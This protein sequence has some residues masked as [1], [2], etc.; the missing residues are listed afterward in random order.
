MSPYPPPATDRTMYFIGVT[1]GRSAVT[2]VFPRWAE[3]LGL[4]A[5][6]K[7]IDFAPDDD[8]ARYREAVAFIKHDRLSLGALVTTHKLN[9]FKAARDLFDEFD[10]FA[11][12]LSEISSI[13]KRGGRLIGCAK[14]PTTV[15]HALETIV[16]DGYWRRTGGEVLI[17]GAGGSSMALT[18][19]LQ[20]RA[21]AGADSPSRVTFTAQDDRSLAVICG[22]HHR[23]GI[24]VPI[25][26]VVTPEPASAD[27]LV[28]MLPASSMVVNA[29]GLGKDRPGSPLT[30]AAV[31]PKSGIAWDFNYRGDLVFLARRGRPRLAPPFASRTDG[32]ISF[33]AGPA[34]SPK[35]STSTFP[36]PGQS[37]I[38]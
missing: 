33:T 20:T 3:A 6:L 34:S 30:D 11:R 19:Y 7:G 4:D 14:D 26:Y 37:S 22:V 1:T 5:V 23:I 35:C 38:G 28:N 17:L 24:T 32:S 36:L 10:P 29:T 9:L 15:G 8:P 27:R 21:E 16:D 13:S 2:K 12:T 25:D 31:F 18:L